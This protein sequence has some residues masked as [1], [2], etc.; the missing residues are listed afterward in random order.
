M[1]TNINGTQYKKIY[2]R[3]SA[4]DPFELYKKMYING[5]QVYSAGNNVT[6]HVDNG[7]S[8]TEEV[9]FEQSCLVPKT[10][11]PSKSGWEFVGWADSKTASEN[12]LSALNMG[13]NAVTLYAVFKQAVTLNYSGNGADSGAVASETKYS[14]YNNGVVSN[15]SF[16]LKDNGYARRGY[17]FSNWDLGV[18]GATITLSTT[19]TA[20]AVWYDNAYIWVNQSVG[21]GEPLNIDVISLS[22]CATHGS[23]QTLTEFKITERAN[24]H[25]KAWNLRLRTNTVSTR[26]CKRMVIDF[27]NY[28]SSLGGSEHFQVI[29]NTGNILADIKAQVYLDSRTVDVSS[30]DYVYI[31]AKIGA[32]AYGGQQECRVGYIYFDNN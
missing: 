14:Y 19:T 17:R 11:T 13:D 8:Y 12:V 24:E 10:F 22:N 5:V 27:I 15:A 23:G 25:E 20:N 32:N 4:S 1:Q 9:E 26:G 7:V 31:D 6:Y 29:S 18:V 28:S 3:K 21:S 30:A 16:T 2:V